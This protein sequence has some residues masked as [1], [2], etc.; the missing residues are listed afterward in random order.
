MGGRLAQDWR[1][2]AF[3]DSHIPQCRARIRSCSSM[4]PA[5][6]DRV[7][8]LPLAR[9]P[10]VRIR[11]LVADR[12]ATGKVRHGTLPAI[13]A[14][15][16]TD[17]STGPTAPTPSRT[18]TAGELPGPARQGAGRHRLRSVT[19]NPGQNTAP[20]DYPIKLGHRCHPDT[21]TGIDYFRGWASRYGLNRGD[22]GPSVAAHRRARRRS[23]PGGR[24]RS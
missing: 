15:S 23:C 18:H 8:Q 13:I 16:A 24:S 3:V 5:G 20:S 11:S 9:E 4:R 17:S 6:V 22:R 14:T 12:A 19:P 7:G 1:E 21:P 2:P 10:T